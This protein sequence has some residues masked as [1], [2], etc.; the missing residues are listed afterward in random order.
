MSNVV[1]EHSATTTTTTTPKTI[2][3]PQV[4]PPL[5]SFN[6]TDLMRHARFYFGF[7]KI[8]DPEVEAKKRR[9]KR[10]KSK[11]FTSPNVPVTPKDLHELGVDLVALYAGTARPNRQKSSNQNLNSIKKAAPEERQVS[12]PRQPYRR[13]LLDT[14]RWHLHRPVPVISSGGRVPGVAVPVHLLD[15]DPAFLLSLSMMSSARPMSKTSS[16][17]SSNSTATSSSSSS[18]PTLKELAERERRHCCQFCYFGPVALWSC[19]QSCRVSLCPTCRYATADFDLRTSN[20]AAL[21]ADLSK[22]FLQPPEVLKCD[23]DE[24]DAKPALL[25]IVVSCSTGPTKTTKTATTAVSSL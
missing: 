19:N 6:T 14:I 17:T 5:T 22:S 25:P 9:K 21:G 3:G 10:Q 23:C 20:T 7:E 8:Y 13:G 11:V 2:T 24:K 1:G 15:A 16:P 12:Q 18:G 4:P